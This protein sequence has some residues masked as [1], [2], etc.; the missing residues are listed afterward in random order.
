MTIFGYTF[1][2]TGLTLFLMITFGIW[3][4]IRLIIWF[5]A[6]NDVERAPIQRKR[7]IRAVIISLIPFIVM[8]WDVAA[9]SYKVNKLCKEQGGMHIYRTAEA[10]G[11]LGDVSIEYWSKHGF[12]FVE[13]QLRKKKL[14][15]VMEDGKPKRYEVD[16]FIS[17]YMEIWQSKII[18]DHIKMTRYA[19]IDRETRDVLGER[20]FFSVYP[21]WVDRYALG[22]TGLTFT[23]W[24]CGDEPDYLVEKTL[25]PKP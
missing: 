21:G 6:R 19:V 5:L 16:H 14:R 8:H 2:M 17:R 3:I 4:L 24:F 22:I 18:D 11:F 10:E 9:I 25:I 13:Y 15:Y 7:V 23:P 12:N 1:Y 20:V